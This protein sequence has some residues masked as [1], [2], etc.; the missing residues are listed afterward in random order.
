MSLVLEPMA[1]RHVDAVGAID[2]QC[3]SRPWSAAQ[4]RTEVAADDRTHLVVRDNDRIVAHAGTLRVL[5]ELHITTVAVDPDHEGKGH[6]TRL[7]IELLRLGI[8]AGATAATL[9]VRAQAQRAQRLYGRLGFAP[10]GIRSRYYDRPTDD[11]VIMWLHDLD[12]PEITER[13]DRV[14]AQLIP[15]PDGAP[16]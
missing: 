1:G 3:Y 8:A 12:S 14:A 4:W 15:I 13:I 10:A 7:C 6:G 11:A 9:E 2:A 16:S 5:D